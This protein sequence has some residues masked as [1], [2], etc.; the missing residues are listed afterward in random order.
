MAVKG[1]H[2]YDGLYFVSDC[3]SVYRGGRRLKQARGKSGNG[4]PQVSLCKQ[5]LR[6]TCSVH[7]LVAEAFIENPDGKATVNHKDGNK[8]NNSV[9]NLEWA[10]YSEN[11]Q[12]AVDALHRKP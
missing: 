5:G 2:G 4:Y 12:H 8:L 7:R 3:G 11:L 6:R 10:T 1:V 9:S